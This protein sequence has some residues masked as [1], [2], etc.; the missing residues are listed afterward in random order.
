VF[1]SIKSLFRKLP[2]FSARFHI[3]FGLSSLVTTVVLVALFTKF[4]PDKLTER[5]NG[6]MAL[7]E[8]IAATSS[9]L[10][11]QG[12]Q[13]AVRSALQ[14]IVSRNPSLNYIQLVRSADNYK[15][16]FSETELA[17]DAALPVNPTTRVTVPLLLGERRWGELHFQ[18]KKDS[19]ASWLDRW[20]NSPFGLMSFMSLLCFPLFYFYLGKMLKEL[21]PS[22]AVPGRVR[23]ALD[24]IAESLLVIDRK[25]DVVLAN[26]AFAELNGVEAESMLGQP[27]TN[28]SWIFDES[29]E[30][31]TPWDVALA[32]G[33]PLRHE[34]IGFVDSE[35]QRRKFIL[36]CSPVMGGNGKAGG[37]LISMD[38][39]TLLEEKEILL[40]Q[41]MEEAEAANEAKSAFLSNMSHEIRTP[42]TAILGFT[43]VLKRG[44]IDTEKD[45]Q[46]HLNT[47]ADSGQHLLELIND[48]LDLSKVESGAMEVEKIE[49]DAPN[50]VNEVIKVLRVKAEEKGIYLKMDIKSDIP[51][52]IQSDPSRLRQIVTNL[53]GNAI[54]FTESGGVTVELSHHIDDESLMCIDVR[55]TGIGMTE[56][57]QSTIF[58]AFTQ[59][60]ASITR[61]FGG[62]GLGLSIS[63]RLAIAMGGNVLVESAE[64]RG[65]CFKVE[66]PTGNA[67]NTQLLDAQTIIENLDT[68]E[69]SEHAEWSFPDCRVLVI[70]DGAENR[71]LLSLVLG[72]LGISIRMGENGQEA[73]DALAE[74]DFDVVLMD[75]Q[76]PVMDGYQAA[77]RMREMGLTLPVVALTANAMKGFEQK[78]LA[79]GYS[80]YMPKPIDL[81]KLTSLLGELLGGE[82]VGV[83]APPK[84]IEAVPSK[85]AAALEEKIYS[86]LAANNPK[87]QKIVEQFVV[88]LEDRVQ[89]MNSCLAEGDFQTLAEM[90]HWLKGSGGTVGFLQFVEPSQELEAA[91]KANDKDRCKQ[92]LTEIE[93]IQSRLSVDPQQ[94]SDSSSQDEYSVTNAGIALTANAKKVDKPVLSTLPM[95]NPRFRAVVE[96]FIPRLDDQQQ[97]LKQ[98]AEKEDYDEIARLAHWLKGS[99]GNVGFHD[100]TEIA[101]E[102]EDSAK[103]RDKD[104]VNAKLQDVFLYTE[105]VRAGWDSLPQLKKTA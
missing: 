13:S 89:H 102:L 25:G 71:E 83:K 37:V 87:F 61:R 1:A 90:A 76:M 52:H 12:N 55:D 22:Q 81:D 19:H 74:E 11:R 99:G 6:R 20:R 3:A 92:M 63:R 62:T 36:N 58:E 100:Y 43:E 15:T 77:G 16:V 57:Q 44:Y 95:D 56:A 38:D 26:A 80:H 2:R 39:V 18:F 60:D 96:R 34:M 17:K 53:V 91:S 21:N 101:Q 47:I 86:P 75:V 70:D 23:S 54:K 4:V 7:A 93:K 67:K 66:L 85:P 29:E 32:S 31:Q 65:S 59:A 46:R 33:E 28:F 10:L 68:V 35:Q 73:L 49:T 105:R 88:R 69:I 30:Q 42:M 8:G 41:S 27:V 94:G 51:Q 64:G 40:R 79:A 98:A 104:G 24:T 72:D 78:V 14:F 9:A 5:Q 45:R 103:R 48:V 50:I 82:Q 97:A 84:A